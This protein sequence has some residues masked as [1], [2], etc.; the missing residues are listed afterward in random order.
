VHHGTGKTEELR[1][2]N[3]LNALTMQGLRRESDKFYMLFYELLP[4][5][6]TPY[7]QIYYQNWKTLIEFFKQVRAE[8]LEQI[9]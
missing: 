7:D 2:G 8:K 6:L 1:V 9:K 5:L 4:F 3:F